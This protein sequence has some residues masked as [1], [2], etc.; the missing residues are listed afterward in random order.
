MVYV[1]KFCVLCQLCPVVVVELEPVEGGGPDLIALSLSLEKQ[2]KPGTDTI[3]TSGG[4]GWRSESK[5]NDIP[6]YSQ[7]V[8][9]SV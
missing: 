8:Y 6:D 1:L 3:V 2:K 4:S 5:W 9:S 7:I